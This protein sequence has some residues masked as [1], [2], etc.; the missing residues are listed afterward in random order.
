MNYYVMFY[1]KICVQNVQNKSC[2]HLQKAW[3]AKKC[4]RALG[5]APLRYTNNDDIKLKPDNRRRNPKVEERIVS[6][7]S[8]LVLFGEERVGRVES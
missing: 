7:A 5:W 3:R 2:G 8:I 1:K 6:S 4:P